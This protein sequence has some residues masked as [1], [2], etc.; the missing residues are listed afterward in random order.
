VDL[1]SAQRYDW[2]DPFGRLFPQTLAMITEFD[3]NLGHLPRNNC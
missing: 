2:N 1:G 3:A